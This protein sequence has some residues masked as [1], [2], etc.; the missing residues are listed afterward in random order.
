LSRLRATLSTNPLDRDI[1]QRVEKARREII[2]ALD[3]CN[4]RNESNLVTRR[5]VA[6][7]RR[8]LGRI[9]GAMDSVRRVRA[10]FD[11]EDQD[12]NDVAL[13]RPKPPKPAPETPKE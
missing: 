11:M 13:P 12:L 2:N 10:L 5:R 9:L 8:D 7:A 4:A 1:A 3:L 6:A